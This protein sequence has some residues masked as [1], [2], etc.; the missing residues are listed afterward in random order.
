MS[1]EPVIAILRADITASGEAALTMRGIALADWERLVKVAQWVSRGRSAAFI[2]DPAIAP[3]Y[4]DAMARR[5]LGALSDAGLLPLP[6]PET[7]CELP[8]QSI[9]EEDACDRA[10]LEGQG[11]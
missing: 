7:I 5:A 3:C 1:P 11:Q 9:E 8:H 6:E 4:P 10:R 2:P